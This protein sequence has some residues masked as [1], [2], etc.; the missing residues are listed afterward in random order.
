MISRV[1]T[2][3]GKPATEKALVLVVVEGIR[4]INCPDTVL[5]FAPVTCKELSVANTR[6]WEFIWAV[7]TFVKSILNPLTLFGCPSSPCC[8]ALRFNAWGV[9]SVLE[10]AIM[11][12]GNRWLND[13]CGCWAYAYEDELII[14]INRIL[15][16]RIIRLKGN[17][18][19]FYQLTDLEEET[20]KTIRE[21]TRLSI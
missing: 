5:I 8:V 15:E 9:I 18:L 14:P 20:L 4:S 12:G 21:W 17:I 2:P 19:F 11:L 6:T 1:Y 10:A 13:C 7:T 3:T 16:R